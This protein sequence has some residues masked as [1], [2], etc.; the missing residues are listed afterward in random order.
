M[1]EGYNTKNYTEQGG[2]KTVIGGTLEFKE[3]AQVK[4]LPLPKVGNQPAGEATKVADVND[5]VNALITGLKEAGYMEKDNFVIGSNL[6]PTPTEEALV[7]N[8][9]KV[10]S[11]VCENN[12]INVTVP[13]AELTAYPS[14]DPNQGTHKWLGLEVKTG[15]DSI[16]G[17]TYC[18]S[19]VFNDSDVADANV[20]GCAPGSFV[21]YIKAE[22]V[23]NQPKVITLSKAG[24]EEVSIT[25]NVI[26]VVE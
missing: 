9:S 14:S 22:D 8:H 19:Y 7:A 12:V 6:C 25:I 3:G 11:V 13:L 23:V 15:V 5:K 4:G 18:G 16:K 2:E 17:I 20:T 10:V 24:Y 26:D 1:G 21:L